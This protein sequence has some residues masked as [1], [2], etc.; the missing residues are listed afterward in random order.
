M[1]SVV[2]VCRNGEHTFSKDVVDAVTLLAELVGEGFDVGPGA[3][4]EN[5]T[6]SG[7]DLLGLPT[8][9][10]LRRGPDGERRPLEPV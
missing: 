4:G 2:A 6:T 10:L 8:R 9:T 1:S 5:L 7:V 3:M